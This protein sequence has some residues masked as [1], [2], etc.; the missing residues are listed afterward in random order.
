MGLII[1]PSIVWQLGGSCSA[2]TRRGID[3]NGQLSGAISFQSSGNISIGEGKPKDFVITIR[4]PLEQAEESERYSNF[5]MP[6]NLPD[7]QPTVFNS[8]FV[9]RAVTANLQVMQVPF[10]SKE[11]RR[12]SVPLIESLKSSMSGKSK[13]DHPREHRDL[14]EEV[15]CQM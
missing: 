12:L 11:Q 9:K 2:R 4:I 8:P 13:D 15:K 5:S 10:I 6:K 14:A 3:G 1:L 7:S